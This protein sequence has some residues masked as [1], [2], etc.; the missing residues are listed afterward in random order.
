M[1]RIEVEA[2]A[3]LD[4]RGTRRD[5]KGPVERVAVMR[6]RCE[7]RVDG[8]SC[9]VMSGQHALGGMQQAGPLLVPAE[10]RAGL[11]REEPQEV[12][13][14]RAPVRLA[15]VSARNTPHGSARMSASD[16]ADPPVAVFGGRCGDGEQ[17]VDLVV[18]A[19]GDQFVLSTVV[20]TVRSDEATHRGTDELGVP[21][22]GLDE[23]QQDP[24]RR[25]DHAVER[26]GWHIGAA[27]R[28][29]SVSVRLESQRSVETDRE[30]R[31]RPRRVRRLR[32]PARCSRRVH[33]GSTRPV[34]QR[35]FAEASDPRFQPRC[36]Y[37]AR[38]PV[39]RAREVEN[40]MPR[41][42]TDDSK[43]RTT[44]HPFGD[45]DLNVVRG[46]P[47]DAPLVLLIHGLAGSTAWWDPVVPML[48]RRLLDSSALTS[49]ATASHRAHDR[50][51][52]RNAGARRRRGSG[53]PR[54]SA[55]SPSS[56][57]RPAAMWQPR[58]PSSDPDAVSVPVTV[59]DTGP[60]P[61]AIIPQGLLSRLA[62][63]PV[64]GRLLWRLQSEATIRKLLHAGAFFRE[65]DIPR[66]CRSRASKGMTH[67][68]FA[69]TARGS[70]EY[71]RLR[72]VP[73]RL[74]AL[75]VARA[76]D[77]RRRGPPISS[78]ARN[79]RVPRDS[80]RTHRAARRRRTHPDARRSATTGRLLSDFMVDVANRNRRSRLR[81]APEA[82][83]VKVIGD[84]PG[85]SDRRRHRS[86]RS[87]S[88]WPAAA[89]QI[90][91]P[92]SCSGGPGGCVAR[93]FYRDAKPHQEAFRETLAALAL[94]PEDRLLEIG[95]GGGIFLEWALATG[96]TARAIDH[97]TEMLAL[98]SRRNVA[99]ITAGRLEL[100]DADAGDLPF[101]DGEFTAAATINAFFFFDAPQA[102][103]AEVYRTLAPAGRIAI[104]T[105]ATAPSIVA[106]RMHLYSDR[107]LLRMLEHAG[108]RAHCRATDGT[109]RADAVGHRAKT[110]PLRS[111]RHAPVRSV[112]T[113]GH[114]PSNRG[115][116]TS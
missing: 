60:S 46:R 33:V 51:R 34:R 30:D 17:S 42:T 6:Q 21:A 13:R 116:V 12:T 27:S 47:V 39:D 106:R 70:L 97:S 29:R 110:R 38:A 73:D 44:V 58:S 111:L 50:V 2:D 89:S 90:G 5:S 96:C 14:A 82:H 57:I 93:S 18:P 54:R 63:L 48:A 10:G 113:P 52:H 98:A 101:S 105:A 104:H 49:E 109:G 92:T 36:R 68:A 37:L 16:T 74:A 22:C 64:P 86:R 91:S 23:Q 40:V 76:S 77:L 25:S 95:C 55:G 108:Y 112:T 81:R 99:A 24:A 83:I 79:R 88:G 62:L 8:A 15:V 43:G 9:E 75:G 19:G 28:D 87:A 45:G 11:G 67:R 114:L 3:R 94:G 80:R 26:A 53:Q 85:R 66:R 69:G 35:T 71:I 72:S 59:I 32:G 107:E 78:V 1:L 61:E 56:G 102:V 84:Q 103:L 100:H 4:Q 7:T 65:V 115:G 20:E 41:G 31:L